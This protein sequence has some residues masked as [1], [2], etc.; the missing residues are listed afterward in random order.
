MASIQVKSRFGYG[1]K[2]LDPLV[3]PNSDLEYTVELKNFDPEKELEELSV[4]ERRDIGSRKRERG[5]RH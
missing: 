2:G 4:P 5:M 1:E 3:P